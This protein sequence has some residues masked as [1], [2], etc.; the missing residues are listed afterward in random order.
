VVVRTDENEEFVTATY[1][2]EEGYRLNGK[3]ELTCDLDTDEWQGQPPTCTEGIEKRIILG[4]QI[5]II[6]F[7]GNLMTRPEPLS[8]KQIFWNVRA[9]NFAL[10]C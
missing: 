5:K 1:R 7:H 9:G 3:S 6:K 4:N 10:F 2:C 8:Q